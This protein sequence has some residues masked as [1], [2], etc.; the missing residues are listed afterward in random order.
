MTDRKQEEVQDPLMTMPNIAGGMSSSS[1][2][3]GLARW[4]PAS[5]IWPD[6][7]MRDDSLHRLSVIGDPKYVNEHIRPWP[8]EG[9]VHGATLKRHRRRPTR[10]T[11]LGEVG[12]PNAW[13]GRTR[14]RLSQ[15]SEEVRVLPYNDGLM[16]LNNVV[17]ES[18]ERLPYLYMARN[19]QDRLLHEARELLRDLAS[20]ICEDLFQLD[21]QRTLVVMTLR[22]DR[23]DSLLERLRTATVDRTWANQDITREIL[24]P[25][26]D[27]EGKS[28]RS[29]AI[30]ILDTLTWLGGIR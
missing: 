25:L 23:L 21:C 11:A 15:C 14:Q 6:D 8:L 1:S 26:L 9:K 7:Q 20:T 18:I 28:L 12:S 10:G 29:I 16:N 24:N 27:F 22:P 13:Y 19:P 3:N 17:I 5:C 4:D 30:S 2:A